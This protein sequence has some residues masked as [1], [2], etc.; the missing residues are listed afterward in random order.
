M[1]YAKKMYSSRTFGG[2]VE[3]S[4]SPKKGTPFETEFTLTASKSRV[5]SPIMCEFG[6]FHPRGKIV[7]PSED[8][9]DNLKQT[10]SK[11]KKGSFNKRTLTRK[12][13]LLPASDLEAT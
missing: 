1:G 4:I 2:D 10:S 11:V 8:T 3:F 13:K 12:V 6:Y 9:I 7:L 5:A